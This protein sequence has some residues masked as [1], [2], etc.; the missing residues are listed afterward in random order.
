[1][2][3]LEKLDV[4]AFIIPDEVLNIL[5]FTSYQIDVTNQ[6]KDLMSD[7]FK[8]SITSGYIRKKYPNVK[9]RHIALAIELVM[10]GYKW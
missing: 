7:T 3:L 5:S 4:K 10:N 6:N 9:S 2:W 1:M 8:H